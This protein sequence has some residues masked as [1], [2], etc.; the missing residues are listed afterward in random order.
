MFYRKFKSSTTLQDLRNFAFCKWKPNGFS[1]HSTLMLLFI[2]HR[3]RSNVVYI[4]YYALSLEPCKVSYPIQMPWLWNVEC[5]P[6]SIL[7]TIALLFRGI[8]KSFN[9][10]IDVSFLHIVHIRTNLQLNKHLLILICYSTYKLFVYSLN[11]ISGSIYLLCRVNELD[12]N[13]TF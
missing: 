6:L 2:G 4:S 13:I 11:P 12:Q 5:F 7:R 8:N 10:S 1:P 3:Q 9:K